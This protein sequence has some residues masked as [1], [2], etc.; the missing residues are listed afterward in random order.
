[1]QAGGGG[2]YFWEF[3]LGVCRPVLQILTK[4][5][6]FSHPF[7]DLASQIHTRFQTWRRSQNASYMFTTTEIISSLLRLGSQQ[8][9][10]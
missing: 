2:G 4:K 10:S 5:C 6:H 9:Y 8:K 7:S 1:M 3:L